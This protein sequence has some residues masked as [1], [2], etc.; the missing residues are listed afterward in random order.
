MEITP[1]RYDADNLSYVISH[2]ASAVAVDGGA[3]DAIV[4]FLSEKGLT[5]RYVVNTHAHPDHTK[6]NRGLLSATHG[7]WIPRERLIADGGL[8]LDG[9][10]IE[11]I[12]T[13]GHTEDSVTFHC[14][15]ALI[16]GDTLF[17]GTVGNCF[18]GD[19]ER[20]YHSISR[21]LGFPDDNR[22]YAGHDYVRDS[23][24]AARYWEPENPEIDRY[25]SKYDPAHVVSTI[26][27]E[28]GVNPYLRVDEPG[29]VS[30]I[31]RKGLPSET[32]LD[33]WISFMRMG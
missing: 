5:L 11:V 12:P 25:L 7:Q 27:E 33:R 4:C 13:P 29:I 20:F 16:T 22:V 17:N 32:A 19:L 15:G 1:F 18:S 10:R 3:V 6:G 8:T 14:H 30:Q 26:G 21:L 23:M 28:R 9:E 2:G 24:A 31:R